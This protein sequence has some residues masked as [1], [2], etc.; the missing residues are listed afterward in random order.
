MQVLKP[1]TKR[2]ETRRLQRILEA[3]C[4][5]TE[6]GVS[7]CI[8]L[9]E[10]VVQRKLELP[11]WA[12]SSKKELKTAPKIVVEA[13]RRGGLLAAWRRV[14]DKALERSDG[15]VIGGLG[16]TSGGEICVVAPDLLCYARTDTGLACVEAEETW[17]PVAK[18]KRASRKKAK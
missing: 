11:S 2:P 16:L 5:P 12:Y 3:H 13:S 17:S 7:D 6:W 9:A 14:L 1:G 8:T 4:G 10:E 15:P 18:K